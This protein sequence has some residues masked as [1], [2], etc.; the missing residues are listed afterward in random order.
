MIRR[1][2]IGPSHIFPG[3]GSVELTPEAV[4]VAAVSSSSV[5]A[6]IVE[7]AGETPA[8]SA[9]MKKAELLSIALGMGLP[10]TKASTKAEILAALDGIPS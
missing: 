3:A 5:E 1:S 7:T 10:V 8:W 9:S 4:P 2:A 6:T